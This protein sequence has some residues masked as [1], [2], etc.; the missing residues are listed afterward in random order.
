[1]SDTQLR[2]RVLLS[3]QA[4]LLGEVS[5]NIRGITSAWND[6]TIEFRAYFDGEIPEDDEESMECVA[7]Q[8]IAGFPEHEVNLQCI[9]LDAPEPLNPHGLTAWVYRRKET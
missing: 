3:F 8:I 5:P 9:R 6:S 4:A 2:C 1:M 7:T